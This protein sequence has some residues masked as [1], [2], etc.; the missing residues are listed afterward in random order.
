M[1]RLTFRPV[2]GATLIV[3]ATAFAA[4]AKAAPPLEVVALSAEQAPGLVAGVRFDSFD[5]PDIDE[6]GNVA[7][8]VEY[9]LGGGGV[10]AGN[11]VALWSNRGGTLIQEV[12]EG[13]QAVGL[14]NM[15]T[16]KSF[17]VPILNR[18]GDIAF[19]S[20]LQGVGVTFEN[21]EAIFSDGINNVLGLVAREGLQ[22]PGVAAGITHSGITRVL[23]ND[24]DLVL[25]SG[26]LKGAGVDSTNSY[27]V[28]SGYNAPGFYSLVVREN[29]QAPDLPAGALL[30]TTSSINP[31]LGGD[32]RCAFR[33][34]LSGTGVTTDNDNCIFAGPTTSLEA[35]REG[36]SAPAIDGVTIGNFF[37]PSINF[38]G[39]ISLMAVLSGADI[40]ATND[41]AI[42][43]NGQTGNLELI[44]RDGDA[45]PIPDTTFNDIQLPYISDDGTTSFIATVLGADVDASNDEAIFADHGGTLRAVVREGDPAPGL[46]DGVVF[47]GDMFTFWRLTA[48]GRGQLAFQSYLSGPGVDMTNDQSIW[49]YDP[50]VGLKL[51]L[52]TGDEI[53][54]ADGD[55]R[56]VSQFSW[57]AG[58]GGSDGRQSGFNDVGQLAIK[59]DFDDG[60]DAIIVTADTDA[61]GTADH[62][63][64]CPNTVNGDQ[65]DDDG[66]GAGNACDDCPDDAGKTAPGVCGCGTSDADSDGDGTPDCFDQCPDDADK[67]AP[68]AC[69]CDTPDTDTDGDLIPDCNDN[70]PANPNPDQPQPNVGG[71]DDDMM[72]TT[73]QCCG[74]GMPAM[75][76]FMLL[77]W[78]GL[79]RRRRARE[80]GVG[81]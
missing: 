39:A 67:I 26:Q 51:V 25:F 61:D 49:Q 77:G 60:T 14:P 79:R 13:Q 28:W 80:S 2:I 73:E 17:V 58:S 71:D 44:A 81:N 9:E 16:Y 10:V 15:V 21:D 75:M 31:V 72:P 20:I 19:E 59:V 27:G 42:F 23:F 11:N 36:I 32:T 53:E 8:S 56:T 63:D 4:S 69:G 47:H 74:G 46:P 43:S 57:S 12:R 34:A 6:A 64:N 30:A 76:P 66:D 24:D 52:R 55:L 41:L 38:D 78:R 62:F 1:P 35:T 33:F 54:V 40:D 18:D 48:N 68:G 22:A 29:E 45:T 37:E 70:D 5:R 65:A 3:G 50:I 7:F